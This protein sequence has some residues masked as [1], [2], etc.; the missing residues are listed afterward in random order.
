MFPKAQKLKDVEIIEAKEVEYPFTP[1]V[2]GMVRMKRLGPAMVV[3]ESK[4]LDDD[5]RMLPLDDEDRYSDVVPVH[6]GYKERTEVTIWTCHRGRWEGIET[7]VN[8]DHISEI[9]E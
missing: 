9:S 5:V 2:A 6:C 7:S 3:T 4:L 1:I 8:F